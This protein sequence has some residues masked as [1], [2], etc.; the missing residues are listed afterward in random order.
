MKNK[1][2]VFG[3]G[4]KFFYDNRPSKSLEILDNKE[5]VYDSSLKTYPYIVQAFVQKRRM[6]RWEIRKIKIINK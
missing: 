1:N 4:R 2:L 6:C 5:I 3:L